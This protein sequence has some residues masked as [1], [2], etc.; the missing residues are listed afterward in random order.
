MADLKALSD[1][2]TKLKRQLETVLYIS[3][4]RDYDDLSG[5]DDY[6]QIKTA[7]QRQQL[8]EYRNIL[9]K[10][11]EVQRS[12]AYFGKPI[13]EVSRIY[14]NESGRYETDKGHY[15]TSGSGIEFLRTEEVYNYDTDEWENAEVW[16]CSRVESRNG[17]YYIVGYSDI[18]MHGLT[19]RVRG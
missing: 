2:M 3:G 4:Y 15:Y 1:E 13:R 11:D 16:T 5:L 17:E 6:K 14:T 9:Y 18:D 8:E 19:V 10:L 12:L 7:D